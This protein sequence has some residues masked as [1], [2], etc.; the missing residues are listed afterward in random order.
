VGD[1]VTTGELARRLADIQQML[2]TL[3]GRDMYLSDKQGTEWRLAELASDLERERQERAA[4]VKAVNGRLDAQ[5]K[6]GAEHRM[7]WRALLLTGV[8]PAAVTLI[9]ILVTLWIS[10]HGGGH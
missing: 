10:H 1:E 6:A 3:V 9:G 5:A 2:A 7:H 8:L 4:D